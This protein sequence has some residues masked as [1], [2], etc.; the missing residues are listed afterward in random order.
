MATP[1]TVAI[2]VGRPAA[3]SS[4]VREELGSLGECPADDN[5]GDSSRGVVA[6]AL[7][8]RAA[9]KLER[10]EP[11]Y[12][13]NSDGGERRPFEKTLADPSAVQAHDDQGD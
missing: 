9:H 6:G 5:R 2:I 13:G 10:D 1:T 12:R 4:T 3:A 8:A 11:C 7:K